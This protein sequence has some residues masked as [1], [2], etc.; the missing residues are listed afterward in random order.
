MLQS[1]QYFG[2]AMVVPNDRCQ[3][4]LGVLV[5]R[6]LNTPTSFNLTGTFLVKRNFIASLIIYLLKFIEDGTRI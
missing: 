6:S 3:M 2:N 1:G 4:N 5:K